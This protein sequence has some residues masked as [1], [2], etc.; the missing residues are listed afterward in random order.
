MK[1]IF[2][3]SFSNSG[4]HVAHASAN[5]GA[6]EIQ[7]LNTFPYPF[8][9]SYD[10]FFRDQNLNA[11]SELI[12]QQKQE[13][14]I[15]NLSLNISL[16]LNFTFYKRI[17]V[18]IDADENLIRTQAE[19]ELKSYLPES[20]EN[21]KVIKTDT[22]YDCSTYKEIAFIAIHK[23][24]IRKFSELAEASAATLGRLILDNHSIE[25]Y[26]LEY[27]LAD[28]GN[29]QQIYK[30]DKF[31]LSTH[32]F[33][34]G[35]YFLSYLDNLQTPGQSMAFEEKILE[36]ARDRYKQ[37]LNMLEQLP[38]I[39]QKSCQVFVHGHD[40]N[41][42]VNNLLQ[43]HFDQDVKELKVENYAGPVDAENAYIEALGVL[44][45][46]QK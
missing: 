9:F 21:Y 22:E 13:K 27:N 29:N 11:I 46:D 42:S 37:S 31:N 16:P 28:V 44:L 38:Y 17:A 15:D 45:N 35:K 39:Q 33:L 34:N 36:L 25:N 18:P 5:S 40:F 4:I 43:N 6:N 10:S 30:I 24:I 2:G 32:L 20:M 41:P 1:N 23:S 12:L 19:W 26:L 3:I 8:I 7:S 14:S